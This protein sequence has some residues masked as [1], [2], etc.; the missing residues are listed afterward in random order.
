VVR[1]WKASG[2]DLVR[3]KDAPAQI[4]RVLTTYETGNRITCLASFVML[5]AEDPSTLFDSE[6]ES[7]E[8]E[9]EDSSD[10]DDE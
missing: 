4:G 10:S 9:E 5:P 1:V 2:K 3:A 7:S 8:N 6:E